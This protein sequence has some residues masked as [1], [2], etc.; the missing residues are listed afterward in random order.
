MDLD[1]EREE[2]NMTTKAIRDDLNTMMDEMDDFCCEVCP[3]AAECDGL[4]LYW[5]CGY[6]EDMMGDEL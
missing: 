6:W 2:T 5:G 1:E 4:M 3:Y